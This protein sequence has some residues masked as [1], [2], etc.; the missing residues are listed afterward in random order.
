MTLLIAHRGA[1]AEAP[2]NTVPAVRKAWKRRS[3]GVE[4]DIHLTRDNR[5]AVIHDADTG[6]V[7]RVSLPV[8]RSS[9]A[10]LQAIDVGRW[11]R[12]RYVGRRVPSF[13]QA[14]R[15]IP[16]EKWLFA[17]LKSG[18]RIAPF[19]LRELASAARVGDRT[20]VCSFK[21]DTIG[22]VRD[23]A[24]RQGVDGLQLG[25]ILG[26]ADVEALREPSEREMLF[27]RAETAGASWLSMHTSKVVDAALVASARASGFRV[28]VWTVDKESEASRLVRVGVD[29]I[30][31]NDPKKV[32]PHVHAAREASSSPRGPSVDVVPTRAAVPAWMGDEEVAEIERL[33]TRRETGSEDAPVTARG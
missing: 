6:R 31:T 32:G 19:A 33:E 25:W 11:K 30:I 26:V 8:E 9:L 10:Q 29:A 5:L 2:E 17:E 12:K 21:L 24:Q 20:M 1:S 27:W 7:A 13:A 23:E 16:A 18:P 22:A 28:A 14:S 3:D 15:V 4:I